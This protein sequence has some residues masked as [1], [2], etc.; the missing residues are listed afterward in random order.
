MMKVGNDV[1]GEYTRQGH[2]FD[3]KGISLTEGVSLVLSLVISFADV[4]F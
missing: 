3:G 2:P 4:T 1:C